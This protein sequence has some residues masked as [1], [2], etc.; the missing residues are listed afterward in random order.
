MSVGSW[1]IIAFKWR[2]LRRAEQD[3]EAFVEVYR[4]DEFARAFDAAR[5]LEGS[6]LAAVFLA[7]CAELHGSTRAPAGRR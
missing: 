1:A 6:P 2:E 4:E 5:D 7:G 3:S